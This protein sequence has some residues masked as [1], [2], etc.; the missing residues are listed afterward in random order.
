[1]PVKK[2]IDP[3]LIHQVLSC[4]MQKNDARAETV[5]E[6]LSTLLHVLWEENEGF[7]GK[8]P[9]GNSGWEYEVYEALARRGLVQGLVFDE[10]GYVEEFP[11]EDERK[12]DELILAAIDA[13]GKASLGLSS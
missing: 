6:Y 13:M 2:N 1:M 3:L 5:G 11:Y 12:A 7:S 8:R 10:D 9:L 4:P